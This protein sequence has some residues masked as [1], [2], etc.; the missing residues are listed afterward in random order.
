[1]TKPLDRVTAWGV[2]LLATLAMTLSYID[3]QALAVLAPTVTKAL[4]IDDAAYGWLGAGFFVAYF[5][6]GPLA[7]ALVDKLGARRS[8]PGAILLWS[9]VAALHALAP[10][11]GTLFGLR[12]A[13]GLAEAP[14]LPSGAQV[15][16]RVL[17]P[18]D[19]ARGMSTL[20]AGMSIGGMLAPPMAIAI[21]TRFSWRWAFVG[22]AAAAALWLPL[23]ML[24]VRRPEV[25]D[26]LDA[27]PAGR[28]ASRLEAALHPAMLRGA[29]GLFAIAPASNFALAWEAKFYVGQVGLAQNDLA[30]YLMASAIVFDVGAILFGDLAS[31][32]ARARGDFSPHRLLLGTAAAIAAIGFVCVANAR[33]PMI[34][35]VGMCFGAIGRGGIVTLVNSDALA[36][37]PQRIV[38]AAGGVM[39]SVHALAAIV[40]NPIV[41]AVV[42]RR[43][44]TEV[45]LAL[46]AWL[47]VLAAVWIAWRPPEPEVDYDRGS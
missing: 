36:R 43:G 46:V 23:W 45:V 21:A 4:A 24:V 15:V 47:V 28:P 26:V 10:G 11:F 14:S 7:G 20:F 12:L 1:V 42:K 2:A 44:Y 38:S 8:L 9:L 41:G 16:Q 22:T 40:V 27:R 34:A 18:A 6:G 32:R 3:R 17:S 19:R 5:V 29:I 35:V 25:R 13:L 33:T 39:A 31:R 37:V 30:P